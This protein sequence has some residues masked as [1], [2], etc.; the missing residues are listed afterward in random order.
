MTWSYWRV[1]PFITSIFFI[2]GVLTLYWVLYNWLIAWVHS[3]R[4]NI[5]DSVVNAWHGVVYM[6]V[7]VFVMQT[8]VVGTN[9]S[10]QF[11]NFQLIALVFCSYFL[12]IHI[13]Y[14]A[15]LPVVIIYMV[16]NQS[17]YYWE[18][19]LYAG[20]MILLFWTMNFLRVWLVKKRYAWAYYLLTVSAYGAILWL[21]VKVKFAFSWDIYWQELL[22]L[23]V[24]TILLYAY[25]NMITK[26]SELKVQ[27]TQFANHDALTRAE[28]YAAYTAQIKYLF[29]DSAKN[30]LSLSMMMFD[31]DHFKAVNDTYGH[32]AGDRVLQQA[33]TIVQTVLDANDPQVKLYRTGGEEFNVLFQGYDLASTKTIVDQIFAAINHLVVKY[34][35]QQIHVS[36]S[37]GVAQLHPGDADPQA[38]YNRVDQNLYYSKRH[39]RMQITAK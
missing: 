27:L 8:T 18:S 32:L 33:T 24:F 1:A 10:W 12:N 15:L 21:F 9:E 6:L 20:V 11:M 13:R 34:N 23:E 22:Y 14:Y 30:N 17:I 38:F 39:G 7:F 36:I 26:D 2:L 31:I 19:W 4:I 35:D 25:V 5:D 3:R 28:N 16:F 29:A 37:V